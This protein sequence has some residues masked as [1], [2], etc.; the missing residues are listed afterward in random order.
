[1][2]KNNIFDNNTQQIG[3][4][5]LVKIYYQGLL[6]NL[7][8]PKVA[9]FFLAL[10]PQFVNPHNVNGPIPFLL[11]GVTFMTTGTVWC[12]ILAYSASTITKALRNNN[13]F[14]KIM[15]KVSG[16]ILIGLGVKILTDK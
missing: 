3:K 4:T 13:K 14:G 6:T 1:M 7:L 9:L 5:D 16:V 10:L 2:S 11:L 8:N 12:L 15:Q